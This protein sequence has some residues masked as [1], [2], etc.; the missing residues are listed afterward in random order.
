ML[1]HVL[2]T[3]AGCL[4]WFSLGGYFL[5]RW[6]WKMGYTEGVADMQLTLEDSMK[7]HFGKEGG[8]G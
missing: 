1:A 2:W 3:M 8:R 6:V 4:L 7:R 5:L